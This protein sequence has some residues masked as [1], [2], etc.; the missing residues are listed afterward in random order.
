MGISKEPTREGS[1][2]KGTFSKSGF[3]LHFLIDR[4][5]ACVISSIYE[6][7]GFERQE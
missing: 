4:T 5:D 7:S 6:R 2:E 3:G 1:H